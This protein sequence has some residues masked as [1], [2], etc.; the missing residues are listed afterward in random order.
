MYSEAF[1]RTSVTHIQG[2]S[3]YSI[4]HT[5]PGISSNYVYITSMLCLSQ[6]IIKLLLL[7]QG[8][9]FPRKLYGA[10]Q[11]YTVFHK[12]LWQ[13]FNYFPVNEMSRVFSFHVYLKINFQKLEPCD[14]NDFCTLPEAK[15]SL[16]N[17]KD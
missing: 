17:K 15:F 4:K 2:S 8:F 9:E 11:Y 12:R 1:K 6:N 5:Y 14:N 10:K 13:N 16:Y 3:S 7:I